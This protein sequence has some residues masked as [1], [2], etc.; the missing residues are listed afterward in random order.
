MHV[1][2]KEDYSFFK[3]PTALDVEYLKTLVEKC[4]IL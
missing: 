4:R 3:L 2:T 1:Y